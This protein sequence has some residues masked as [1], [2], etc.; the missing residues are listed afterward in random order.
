MLKLF[1]QVAFVL[2]KKDRIKIFYI[3]V[4]SI[5]NALLEVLGIG[6]VIP[7]VK[8]LTSEQP[9]IDYPFLNNIFAS[10]TNISQTEIILYGMIF[11]LLVFFIKMIFISSLIWVIENFQLQIKTKYSVKLF[12]NYIFKPYIFHLNKN[13]AEILRNC[14]SVSQTFVNSIASILMLFME[15]IML[16]GVIVFL[17]IY[18]PLG[19]ISL[20]IIFGA[21]G[22]AYYQFNRTKLTLWAKKY[23]FMAN[24]ESK[25]Y[26][27]LLDQ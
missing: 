25:L 9:F 19:S 6:L 24:K 11:L 17:T 14:D 8:I 18:Q 23:C 13:S 2:E 22:Y 27:S 21:F 20:I 16:F 15:L 26:K 1:K 10:S 3:F 5:I 7:F 12:S 4:L